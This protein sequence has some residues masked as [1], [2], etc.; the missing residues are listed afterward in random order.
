MK[1][2]GEG[3]LERQHSKD[4][5]GTASVHPL[6]CPLP[7]SAWDPV[8]PRGIPVQPLHHTS[9]GRGEPSVRVPALA[10]GNA[11]AP[12]SGVEDEVG[13]Q[14]QFSSRVCEF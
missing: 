10:Q 6:P 2:G 4:R 12:R 14:K 11:R 9:P 5:A 1:E 13:E 8:G 7:L 3:L